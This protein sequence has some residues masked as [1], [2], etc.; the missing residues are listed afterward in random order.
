MLVHQRVFLFNCLLII[1]SINGTMHGNQSFIPFASVQQWK[2][3]FF[4]NRINGTF[5]LVKLIM[6]QSVSFAGIYPLV[7]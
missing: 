2:L 5:L 1:N 4:L 7:N 6:S 3:F